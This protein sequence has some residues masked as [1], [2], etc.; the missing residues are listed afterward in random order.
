MPGKRVHATK[1]DDLALAKGVGLPLREPSC[2][3]VQAVGGRVRDGVPRLHSDPESTRS[4][5]T[6]NVDELL[7]LDQRMLSRYHRIVNVDVT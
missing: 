3:N 7:S 2:A 5:A 6:I 4:L 1:R